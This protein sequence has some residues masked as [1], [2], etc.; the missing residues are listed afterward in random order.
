MTTTDLTTTARTAAEKF[1]MDE[2]A[3][4]S[5]AREYLAQIEGIDGQ[6]YDE[7]ELP[8]KV[9]DFIIESIRQSQDSLTV[10]PLDRVA[11]CAEQVATAEDALAVARAERDASIL[12]AIDAGTPIRQIAMSGK[13]S[14]NSIYKII[15]NAR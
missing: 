2:R 9:A 10:N 3:A 5:A 1:D 11:E 8:T 7:D 4:E 12:A 6:D 14:R 15:K 13:I